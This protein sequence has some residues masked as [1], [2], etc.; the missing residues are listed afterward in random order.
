MNTTKK[1]KI[2]IL[3]RNRHDGPGGLEKVLSIVADEFKKQGVSLYFYGLYKPSYQNFTNN[4]EHIYFLETPLALQKI[5]K[6]FSKKAQRAIHKLFVRC[7]GYTLFKK[8]G[9]DQVDAL[10]TLDLSKQFLKNYSFLKTFKNKYKIP[11]VSWV[12]SSL[13]NTS[14]KLQAK[15]QNKIEIFD[16]HLA[17]SQG[18]ANEIATLYNQHNTHV[19]YNPIEDAPLLPRKNNAFIYIGR[20]DANKRVH[21]LLKVLQNLQGDWHLDIYGSTG[22]ENSDDAFREYINSLNLTL[23]VTFHGWVNNPWEHIKEAGV[24]LLNSKQEGFGLV[25]A[26]AMMRGIPVLSSNCPVGPSE[27]IQHGT[28]GWLYPIDAEYQIKDILQSI[29]DGSTKLPDPL[30]IQN[31]VQQYE[32]QSYLNNFIENINS[33]VIENK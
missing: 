5:I 6:F 21:S 12:H 18:I 20:I 2:G 16:M 28:N 7:K 11:L 10:I 30:L 1:L 14:P 15:I 23:K 26:E 19:I 8:M 22:S 29:L 13:S 31:S 4:F 17:I 25:I 9:E 3:L 33:Y 27:L 24:L 32:T